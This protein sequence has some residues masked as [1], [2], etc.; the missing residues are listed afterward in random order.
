[1]KKA[2][3][4]SVFVCL[5]AIINGQTVKFSD[6][7]IES[8][9]PDLIITD[10][11]TNA[12]VPQLYPAL[13]E[14]VSGPISLRQLGQSA[15]AFGL[16]G[17]RQ[18]LWVDPSINAASF[19]HRM[20]MP[21]NGPGSGFL[22]YD[23]SI[24][25]GLTWVNNVQIYDPTLN[26]AHNARYPQQ[27]IYNPSGNTDPQQAVLGYFAP[28]LDES[29]G[30]TW[31]G[32][33]FGSHSFSTTDAPIQHDQSSSND[34]LQG[35]PSAYTITSQGMAICVDPAKVE[36]YLSYTDF[37]ILTKGH[38]NPDTG[39]FEME[40]F[41][42]EMPAGGMSPVTGAAANVADT[43]VAFA[44][45]GLTGFIAYLSDN[46]ENSEESD[47]C[48]Y[49]I[50]Y[51]T[52]DGGETWIGPFNVQLGGPNGLPVVHDYLRDELI[53]ILFDPP[54][55]PRDLIPF[56]TAFDM[57]LT[58]DH[59]GNPHLIF[60]VGVGSQEYS[61]Y[62]SH[63]GATG[64]DGMVAMIHAFSTNGGQDWFGNLL[65]LVNTF[66]GEFPYTGGTPVLV[67]NRPYVASNH[68]GT[69]LFFSWI[70]TDVPENGNNDMPD[71]YC[72]G[73]DVI[74]NTYSDK[75]LVTQFSGAWFNSFMGTGSKYVFDHGDGSYTIPFVYQQI[76]PF[77]LLDP[78]QFWYIDNFIL[79]DADL[80]LIQGEKE[81][82]V[83][84]FSVTQ[85]YPNPSTGNTF[86]DITIREAAGVRITITNLIG[87]MVWET[88]TQQFEAGKHQV[89]IDTQRLR[90]GAYL[91]NTYVDNKLISNKMIVQ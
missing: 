54:L 65:G 33:G 91:Y 19:I 25:G 42:E 12:P 72:V 59:N 50:L 26:D 36:S 63:A 5:S 41:L 1:M 85:N 46:G 13:Y 69:K 35:V 76:N 39:D 73:Y 11:S 47:G 74:N 31:G 22:A 49:P 55:P 28:T 70:D 78:V 4:F 58:V 68:A 9:M 90:P 82:E 43:K 52:T 45:D 37:M 79:T 80:G 53:E 6:R 21:P 87:Q 29:N 23:Y 18:F 16:L 40:Q 3:L 62:T 8:K 57:G 44:P 75:Y 2:L 64:C 38:Y 88:G 15:N 51:R 67:D 30:D 61:I 10:Q 32:Y 81:L 24:D 83:Y 66:R 86:V 56:T 71:I 89:A 77:E 17:V 60:N 34:F 20:A 27:G 84:A 14:Q 48:Y 7:L